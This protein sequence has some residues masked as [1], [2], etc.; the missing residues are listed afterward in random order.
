MG[1]GWISF[2]VVWQPVDMSGGKNEWILHQHSESTDKQE[3]TRQKS[4]T[5]L[6]EV[7]H[8]M[9]DFNSGLIIANL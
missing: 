5:Y 1:E 6:H 4:K 7:L 8:K 3:I 2:E 9:K